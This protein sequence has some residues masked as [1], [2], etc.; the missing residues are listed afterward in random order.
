MKEALKREDSYLE[1]KMVEKENSTGPV[2][3]Q[4][5]PGWNGIPGLPGHP[6]QDGVQGPEGKQGPEGPIGRTGDVGPKGVRGEMGPVGPVGL[7][8]PKGPSGPAGDPGTRGTP[9]KMLECSRIGGMM[10][11]DVCFKSIEIENNQDKLP[12]DCKAWQPHE[13]WDERDWWRL[14]NMFATSSLTHG[15]DIGHYGGRCSNFEAVTAFTQGNSA[16][17]VWVNSKTFT[18][19]PTGNG[20]SCD[21]V[22]GENTMALYACA[23]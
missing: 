3:P 23:F 2:G 20:R 9:S 21:L 17:R 15:M 16:T 14:A 13:E 5:P 12:E 6:G 4:G 18:F 7:K 10:Y 19:D 11:R 1:N 8:G 22:N